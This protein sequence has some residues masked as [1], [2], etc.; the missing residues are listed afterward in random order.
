MSKKKDVPKEEGQEKKV[1]QKIVYIDDNSTIADMSGV[2]GKRNDKPKSTGREKVQ[3]FFAVMK[4]MVLPMLVTLLAF[5]V[6]YV[7]LLAITG[8]I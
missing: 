6:G 5:T 4:K 2:R 7:I 3:T 1:E 8:K